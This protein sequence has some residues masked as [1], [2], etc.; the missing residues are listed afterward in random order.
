WLLGII[1]VGIHLVDKE[2]TTLFFNETMAEIDG[3]DRRDVIGQNVFD[4]FPSL[5]NESSTLIGVLRTGEEIV[6]K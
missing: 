5:T 2:G 4:L 1:N 3:L 6:D